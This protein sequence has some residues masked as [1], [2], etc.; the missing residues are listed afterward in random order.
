MA[1]SFT[2]KQTTL[3]NL[4]VVNYGLK[5]RVTQKSAALVRRPLHY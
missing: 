2:Y 5:E 3:K 1:L 4:D